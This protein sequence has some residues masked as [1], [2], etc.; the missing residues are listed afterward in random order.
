MLP[1]LPSFFRIFQIIKFGG[2]HAMPDLST[3]NC[4]NTEKFFN[5]KELSLGSVQIFTDYC[6]VKWL[7]E[8]DPFSVLF[9]YPFQGP[10]NLKKEGTSGNIENP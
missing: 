9:H 2:K 10:K 4:R 1:K 5:S 6:I 8:K 3:L 7:K